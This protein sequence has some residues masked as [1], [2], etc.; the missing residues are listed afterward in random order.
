MTGVIAMNKPDKIKP[1][2]KVKEK[3]S[4]IF[5]CV[6]SLFWTMA[7]AIP[8]VLTKENMLINIVAIATTPK[9]SGVSIR[10]R[11]I[12]THN[13]TKTPIY[14]ASD[15][16]RTPEM[17]CFLKLPSTIFFSHQFFHF[18]NAFLELYTGLQFL[19][20]L[21]AGADF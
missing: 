12:V 14:L 8:I 15:V 19:Q 21:M 16:Y 13:E 9:S 2:Q 20:L 17:N 10:E 11:T 5:F 4:S 6:N 1:N 7:G 3:I 18:F